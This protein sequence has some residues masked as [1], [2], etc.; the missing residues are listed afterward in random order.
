MSVSN[1]WWNEWKTIVHG[2][3]DFQTQNRLNR[4][5]C[6]SEYPTQSSLNGITSY[7]GSLVDCENGNSHLQSFVSREGANSNRML[8]EAF[9]LN[10]RPNWFVKV[11]YLRYMVYADYGDSVWGV[12]QI[13]FNVGEKKLLPKRCLLHFLHEYSMFCINPSALSNNRIDPDVADKL[14]IRVKIQDLTYPIGQMGGSWNNRIGSYNLTAM[15][16]CNN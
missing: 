3:D 11:E 15:V 9:E 13:R 4:A 14:F 5:E 6:I 12:R 7:T 8:R 2:G 10:Q 16:C 1:H